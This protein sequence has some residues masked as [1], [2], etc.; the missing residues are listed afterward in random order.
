VSRLLILHSNDIHGRADG[1]ARIGTLVERLRRENG[2]SAVLYLDAGDV[3]DAT[4]RLSN[5]TKGTAMLRLLDRAGCQA[6][7]VGNASILRYGPDVLEEQARSVRFPYL[8]ANLRTPAGALLPGVEPAALLEIGNV[9]I[10]V[11]GVTATTWGDGRHVYQDVFG[12]SEVD[13]EPLVREQAGLLRQQG[14]GVVVLLS[15]L[16]LPGDREVAAAAQG[17]VDLVIGAHSHDLLPHGE[18]VGDVLVTQAGAFA[19]HL[20]VVELEARD[21]FVEVRDVRV[22]PVPEDTP[23]HP[24]IAHEADAIAAEV[25]AHLAEVIGELADPLDY[26]SDRECAAGSFMADVLRERMKAD[27]AVATAG[28]SFV[29]PLPAGQLRRGTLFDVCPS[30]GNPG[31]AVLTGTQLRELVARG[32]APARAAQTP[33]PLRGTPQGLLHLSGAEVRDGTLHVG[34]RPV[35][36]GRTY[37]VAGSDWELDVLGGY[38][39]PS[40][41]LDVEYD[42]PTILREAVEDY[43]EAHPLVRRPPRRLHGSLDYA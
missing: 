15:H 7:T 17:V 2:D 3:E 35:E 34:G 20:G 26:S 30:P 36:G 25:E 11:T 10:G 13:V 19:E 39:D 43:F 22:L 28:A 32:L 9:S 12:L 16:G 31:V 37:R 6:A 8:L 21:G 23:P 1:L 40:W 42:V 29:G 38:A 14:A 18:V 24:A 41:G 4:N 5:V 33:R 27:L